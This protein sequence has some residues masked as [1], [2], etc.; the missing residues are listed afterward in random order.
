LAL[1][2][3]L[4][5]GLAAD[6]WKIPPIDGALSGELRRNDETAP[7]RWSIRLQAMPGGG[8]NGLASAEGPGANLQAEV[9]V[10]ASGDGVWRMPAGDVDLGRWFGAVAALAPAVTADLSVAGSVTVSGEGA[11]RRGVIGGHVTLTVRN[12]RLDDSAHKLHL[13]GVAVRLEISDLAA[14]RSAPRQELSWSAGRYDA[15]ALGP[16]RVV[17]TLDGDSLRVESVTLGLFGGELTLGA[18]RL[19][20][21][22]P[23]FAV[24][25]RVEGAEIAAL[26]AY[27]PPVLQEGRGRLDGELSFRRTAA[28]I[29]FGSGRL[30]L[31]PGETADL[32]LKPTPGLLSGSL[33]RAALTL[34][35]GLQQ[36]ELGNLP[37]QAQVLEVS[38]DPD[39]DATGR[40]AVVRI[41]GGPSDP[42]L[43][44]PI[45]LNINV[46][47]PLESLISFGT[48][49]RLRFGG[50]K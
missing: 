45:D 8:R 1:G 44:A 37:L 11:V 13:E 12:G 34:Y 15:L 17:F 31:R 10:D 42:G 25:A 32:R 2:S 6:G 49:S 33:P 47:G 38:F 29:Q 16:G 50:A 35:P 22:S 14:R 30:S 40:T 36:V 20:L 23:E 19:A 48:N 26:Q 43:R 4:M 28:G 9:Q 27:L 21:G 46:R 24:S 39:G 3:G 7:L 41:V 18:F 5:P